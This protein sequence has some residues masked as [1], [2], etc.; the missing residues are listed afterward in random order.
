M[1]MKSNFEPVGVKTREG[2]MIITE[3]GWAGWWCS[4]HPDGQW[5]TD[6]KGENWE[7]EKARERNNKDDSTKNLST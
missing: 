5:V 3:G 6:Y 1:E 7:L 4:K 2:R